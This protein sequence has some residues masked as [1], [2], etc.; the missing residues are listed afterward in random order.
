MIVDEEPGFNALDRCRACSFDAKS[1][2]EAL[3]RECNGSRRDF[4]GKPG[5]TISDR[6]CIDFGVKLEGKTGV[7][8]PGRECDVSPA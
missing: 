4:K 5:I 2:V 1:V 8:D 3:D 7:K 6:E